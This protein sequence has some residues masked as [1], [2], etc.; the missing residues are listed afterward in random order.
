ME[1][2]FIFHRLRCKIALQTIIHAT[3]AT[4][5]LVFFIISID[6]GS[7]SQQNDNTYDTHLSHANALFTG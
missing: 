1:T 6:I 4:I 7:H 2:H 5:K 3:V